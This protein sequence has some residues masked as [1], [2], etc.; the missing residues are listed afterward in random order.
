MYY[1]FE[2]DDE[3][4][5]E[6]QSSPHSYRTHFRCKIDSEDKRKF[7]LWVIEKSLNQEIGCN[8]ATI[9]S[10]KET[11]FVIEISNGKENKILPTMKS[12]CFPQLNERVQPEK[13]ACDK[14]NHSKGLIY[15][16]D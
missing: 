13:F 10:N 16:R 14:I 11:E 1:H 4:T 6:G 2:F 12:I 8:P 15:I 7:N 3:T 9:R 5:R